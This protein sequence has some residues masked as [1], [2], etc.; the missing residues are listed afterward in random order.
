[1]GQRKLFKGNS[2]VD[3]AFNRSEKSLNASAIDCGLQKERNRAMSIPTSKG[4]SCIAESRRASFV[5]AFNS[6]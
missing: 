5:D 3:R 6:T 4:F 1:M 2:P